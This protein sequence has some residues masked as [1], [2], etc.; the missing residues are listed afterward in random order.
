[1]QG[2]ADDCHRG[3]QHVATG[4]QRHTAYKLTIADWNAEKDAI[5][6]LGKDGGIEIDVKSKEIDQTFLCLT[7]QD[8]SEGGVLKVTLKGAKTLRGTVSNAAGQPLEGVMIYI[9]VTLEEVE[10]DDLYVTLYTDKKGKYYFPHLPSGDVWIE[11]TAEGY[12]D[13]D[14]DFETD[15]R[16]EH[17]KDF[18]LESE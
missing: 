5:I 4:L 13:E 2:E 18:R 8:P 7:R 12:R 14:K 9:E 11:V 6:E 15:S 10:A 1:M 17:V 16:R 3:C